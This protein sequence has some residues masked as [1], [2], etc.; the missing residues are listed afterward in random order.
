MLNKLTLPVETFF[1]L[2]GKQWLTRGNSKV[3]RKTKKD[4]FWKLASVTVFSIIS[5]SEFSSNQPALP[6]CKQMFFFQRS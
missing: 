2:M 5:L 4:I 6:K 3:E 1:S